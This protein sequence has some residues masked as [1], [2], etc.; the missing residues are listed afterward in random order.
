MQEDKKLKFLKTIKGVGINRYQYGNF[1]IDVDPYNT[2][3]I[4]EGKTL[5]YED[6]KVFSAFDSRSNQMLTYG[7]VNAMF[8]TAEDAER[9]KAD[10]NDAVGLLKLI[11][12]GE[13]SNE[14]EEERAKNGK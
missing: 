1:R 13:F 8:K 12:S 7:S 11:N 2:P 3:P 4:V 6:T 14:K 9:V 10:V 5:P